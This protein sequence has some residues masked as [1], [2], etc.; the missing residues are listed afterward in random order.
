MQNHLG[1]KECRCGL[2]KMASLERGVT[3][4]LLK[5]VRLTYSL[6][7]SGKRPPSLAKFLSTS[8]VYR[9]RCGDAQQMAQGVSG[10]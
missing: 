9:R 8:D 3:H 1:P 4:R 5:A 2:D 7:V 6:L 10:C